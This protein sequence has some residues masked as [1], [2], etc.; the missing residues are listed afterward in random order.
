MQNTGFNVF[1][2]NYAVCQYK[3]IQYKN[4]RIGKTGTACSMR[5]PPTWRRYPEP[6]RPIPDAFKDADG[7]MMLYVRHELLCGPFFAAL[8]LYSPKPEVQKGKWR[9]PPINSA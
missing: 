8:L 7:G 6:G 5:R 4:I 1:I 9:V 2:F 3:N